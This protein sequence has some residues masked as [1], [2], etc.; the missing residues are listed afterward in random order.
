M[1]DREIDWPVWVVLGRSWGLCVRSWAALG[2]YV[3]CLVLEISSKY[4]GKVGGISGNLPGQF[5]AFSGK[6]PGIVQE[7]SWNFPGTFR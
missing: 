5:W 2:A 6:F 3:D 1:V 4:P 7:L